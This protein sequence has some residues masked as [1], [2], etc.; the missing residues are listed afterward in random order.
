M[1]TCEALN[2]QFLSPRMVRYPLLL[3]LHPKGIVLGDG[4]GML[5]RGS[6]TPPP[7]PPG[8]GTVATP[9]RTK[10]ED[11]R[12]LSPDLP[13]LLPVLSPREPS[14]CPSSS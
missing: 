5:Y 8:I 11:V 14:F 4:V 7:H 9:P 10:T 1:G 6:S 2:P 13:L 12:Q 3:P